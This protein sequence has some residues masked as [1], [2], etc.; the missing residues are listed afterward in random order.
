MEIPGYQDI[1]WLLVINNGV[2]LQ[3]SNK[4]Q[5]LNLTITFPVAYKR[6][7]VIIGVGFVIEGVGRQILQNRTITS[8]STASDMKNCAS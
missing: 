1:F 5:T 2:L 8:F 3:F 6:I 4:V 7:P